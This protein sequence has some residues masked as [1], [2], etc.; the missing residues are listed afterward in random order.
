MKKLTILLAIMLGIV[1]SSV[2]Q[3]KINIRAGYKI[4]T[5]NFTENPDI[6]GFN[7]GV[8]YDLKVSENFYFRPGLYYL[9]KWSCSDPIGNYFLEG[10][11]ITFP[12]VNVSEKS[13]FKSYVNTLEIPL[14]AVFKKGNFDFEIGPYMSFELASRNTLAGEKISSKYGYKKFD[15][16]FKGSLGYNI[17]G[18]YYLGI[19]YENGIKNISCD[20]HDKSFTQNLSFNLGYKF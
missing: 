17:L 6:H 1:F 20:K 14:M 5:D 11:K 10:Y 19:S 3:E 8:S 2:A 16:G 4:P 12:N 9:L 7:I 15:I 13:R 18:K